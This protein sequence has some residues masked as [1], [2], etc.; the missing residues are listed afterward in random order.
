MVL[1]VL[2]KYM[3]IGETKSLCFYFTYIRKY[4]IIHH[5]VW[6]GI[7]N[8]FE[9]INKEI[10]SNWDE[11]T[12]AR[13]LYIKSCQK[14]CY[15]NRYLFDDSEMNRKIRNRSID[16]TNYSDPRIICETWASQVYIPLLNEYGIKNNYEGLGRGHQFVTVELKD[17]KIVADAC[18][19]SDTARVKMKNTTR[20]FYG[21]E[22]NI[23]PH[24]I[25]RNIDI[26]IGYIKD[27]Y[28]NE[29]LEEK[30]TSTINEEYDYGFN[31]SQNDNT[32]VGIFYL[33]K[34]YLYD[35]N[36]I[37]TF[38]DS[39]FAISYLLDKLLPYRLN[40]KIDVSGLTDKSTDSWNMKR[41]YT[42]QLTCDRLYF[43]LED[44][45]Y[46]DGKKCNF[47]EITECDM[48]KLIKIK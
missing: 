8:L 23:V 42:L 7:M 30:I 32:L 34:D 33:I 25:I 2:K 31:Y 1:V 39:C 19:C 13:Y 17:Q 6:G 15:D 44:N 4:D 3:K 14:F 18:I 10:D 22:G 11:L 29:E 36:E 48:K 26:N 9:E 43:L 35:L 5:I 27:K 45:N 40:S 24:E 47:Y 46:N 38:S 37:K 12:L 21:C 16:L 20:G 28:F 41:I